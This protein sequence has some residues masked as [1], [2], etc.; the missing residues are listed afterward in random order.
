MKKFKILKNK[1]ESKSEKK[2]K[3]MWEVWI[4]FEHEDNLIQFQFSEMSQEDSV[5][6]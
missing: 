5:Y 6:T 2:I 4:L 1:K 3:I